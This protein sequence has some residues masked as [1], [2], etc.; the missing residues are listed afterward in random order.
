[1]VTVEMKV[2]SL[3]AADPLAGDLSS[4]SVNVNPERAIADPHTMLL[5]GSGLA[6]LAFFRRCKNAA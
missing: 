1:M 3:V 5:L 2:S 4:G 6:R